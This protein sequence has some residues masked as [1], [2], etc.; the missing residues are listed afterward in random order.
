MDL[1]PFMLKNEADFAT[2]FE[3]VAELLRNEIAIT[4][5]Y[6][7]VRKPLNLSDLSAH[8]TLEESQETF[9]GMSVEDILADD[10]VKCGGDPIHIE[11]MLAELRKYSQQP[12]IK[13]PEPAPPSRVQSPG[14]LLGET[15]NPIRHIVNRLKRP[16]LF[17][18]EY[19]NCVRATQRGVAQNKYLPR[20]TLYKE[21]NRITELKSPKSIEKRFDALPEMDRQHVEFI[22]KWKACTLA[23]ACEWIKTEMLRQLSEQIRRRTNCIL[24]EAEEQ[25]EIQIQH[26]TPDAK[27]HVETMLGVAYLS[28]GGEF[29][30]YKDG[31]FTKLLRQF[32]TDCEGAGHDPDKLHKEHA[33][34]VIITAREWMGN[35]RKITP[36]PVP[37]LKR[38][39]TSRTDVVKEMMEDFDISRTEAIQLV[40]EMGWWSLHTETA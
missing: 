2:A 6:R 20:I 22:R 29:T 10:F 24:D 39:P 21:L 11:D 28:A 35:V 8:G 31:D 4:N 18:V 12:P 23:E 1:T 33:E 37:P 25:A 9:E 34:K 7:T 17:Q 26:Q 13:E 5:G 27:T 38:S 36:K 3:V 15:D 14:W 16:N 32:R 30:K 40:K 19:V